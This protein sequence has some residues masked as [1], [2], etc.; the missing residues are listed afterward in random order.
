MRGLTLM[1]MVALLVVAAVAACGEEDVS[2]GS[3]GDGDDN[4]AGSAAR[5]SKIDG[6]GNLLDISAPQWRCVLDS[7]TGLIWAVKRDDSTIHDKDNLFTW[8]D[9][10]ANTNQGMPGAEGGFN[11][12]VGGI[13]CDTHSYLAATNSE[14]LCG[15]T[16]WRLPTAAEL[17]QLSQQEVNPTTQTQFFPVI[18]LASLD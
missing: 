9:E 11:S 17:Q 7:D 15:A 8:F 10:D 13:Q 5:L 6:A 1:Q 16:N 2:L 3:V 18:R 12:C 4:G 14:G